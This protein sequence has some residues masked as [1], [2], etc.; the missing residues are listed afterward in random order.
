MRRKTFLLLTSIILLSLPSVCI[1]QQN[2]K[3]EYG[4]LVD[5]TGSMRT[6]FDTVC[7]LARAVAHQVHDHGPVSIFNFGGS[8]MG[9]SSRAVAVARI[10]HTQDEGLLNRT[11][12]SLYVEGGQT[13]LL[14]AI[15]FMAARL[16]T[17]PDATDRIIILITDGEDRVSTKKQQDLIRQLKDDKVSVY[18]IGLVRELEGGS[19]SKAIKLL[20]LLTQETGGRV[21]FPKGDRIEIQSL[22][23]ELSLPI[24]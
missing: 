2:K 9:P 22:L 19:R 17:Q 3:L 8:G 23:A 20:T 15:D 10:E 6:Q 13:T 5:S 12:D 4:I 11:I 24:Q 21:V 7:N 14:D 18:A 1:A 16:R